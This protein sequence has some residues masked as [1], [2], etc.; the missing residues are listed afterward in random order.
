MTIAT[1]RI[2]EWEK[3]PTGQNVILESGKLYFVPPEKEWFSERYPKGTAV[4]ITHDRGTVKLM[5][6][7]NED[8]QVST[9]SLEPTDLLKGIYRGC[10]GGNVLLETPE[11]NRGIKA[12]LGLIKSLSDQGSKVKDGDSITLGCIKQEGILIATHIGAG[13]V[14]AKPKSDTGKKTGT[15]KSVGDKAI[16]PEET[17]KRA[18]A[19]GFKTGT[20]VKNTEESE[21]VKRADE[22]KKAIAA[23]AAAKEK[24]Q[25]DQRMKDNEEYARQL[26]AEQKG[27][28]T[29]KQ[30][31]APPKVGG[32]T[33]DQEPV[34]QRVDPAP[35]AP[36]TPIME[37]S[38]KLAVHIDLGSYSNFDLEVNQPS[39]D[40][41]RKLLEQESAPVIALCKRIMRDAKEGY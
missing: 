25:A 13:E 8:A 2:K 33:K 35:N 34:G 41:A 4:K 31:D 40:L 32:S 14:P 24:A 1:G 27:R 7:L 3:I 38:V 19:A 30:P 36:Q 18:E 23:A 28:E 26:A 20:E 17:A 12:D 15:V 22:N 9:K 16:P 11:G 6:P 39:G 5:E 10:A 29:Q 21:V 37:G